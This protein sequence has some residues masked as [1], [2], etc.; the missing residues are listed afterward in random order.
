MTAEALWIARFGDAAMP[1]LIPGYPNAGVV[2]LT[3]GRLAGGDALYYYLGRYTTNGGKL[4]AHAKIVHYNGPAYNAFETEARAFDIVI[5]GKID[6]DAID[7]T[8]YLESTPERRI[9]VAFER[10]VTF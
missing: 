10:K 1:Q 2:V 8:M 9:P 4:T 3:D 6:G 5:E 7:G